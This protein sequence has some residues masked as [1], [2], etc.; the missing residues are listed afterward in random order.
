MNFLTQR[1]D[2]NRSG[3]YSKETILTVDTVKTKNFRK[4]SEFFVDGSVYA[5]PLVASKINIGSK[6]VDLLIVA[7]MHN[8][9]YAF[10]VTSA[11]EYKQLW[12]QRLI[13]NRPEHKDPKLWGYSIQ[14]PHPDIGTV[15]RHTTDGQPWY[16]DISWEV[17]I[18]ST[19]VIDLDDQLIYVV[20]T[21]QS[22]TA[23]PSDPSGTITHT[24]WKLDLTTGAD[25][26]HTQIAATVSEDNTSNNVKKFKS[27]QHIQRA[28]LAINKNGTAKEVY[29]AFAGY[30]DQCDWQG[31]I[32]GYE[33][34]SIRVGS[35]PTHTF[36]TEPSPAAHGSGIWQ[37]GTGPAVDSNGSLYVATGNGYDDKSLHTDELKSDPT[38]NPTNFAGRDKYGCMVLKLSSDLKKVQSSY[39]PDPD[40]KEKLS[41]KDLDLGSG[42]VLLIPGKEDNRALAVTGGKTN[43]IYVMRQD[44]LEVAEQQ[45]D[46]SPGDVHTQHHLHG[47]PTYYQDSNKKE[48]RYV[49]PEM[50]NMMKYSLT[51]PAKP[52]RANF[53]FKDRSAI[54]GPDKDQKGWVAGGNNGMPGGFMT[55]SCNITPPLTAPLTGSGIVWANHP[56]TGNA[57]QA[58]RP[59][60]LYA[61]DA[62]NINKPIW[63]SR[64][65]QDEDL[66]KPGEVLEK[67][68]A[69]DD[70]GNF[71]KF[72]CPTV[73][74]GRVY[75]ASMGGLQRLDSQKINIKTKSSPH[76]ADLSTQKQLMM[77]AW[78]DASDSTVKT[79]TST[80]S[81]EW[82]STDAASVTGATSQLSPC[83]A[84]D[85]TGKNTYIAWVD[86]STKALKMKKLSDSSWRNA[87]DAKM[88]TSAWSSAVE[89]SNLPATEPKYGPAITFGSG[90][91][92]LAWVNNAG[93][94]SVN[95]TND[96]GTTWVPAPFN[97]AVAGQRPSS[98]GRPWLV[99]HPSNKDFVLAWTDQTSGA[100]NFLEFADVPTVDFKDTITLSKEPP[101]KDPRPRTTI[102]NS[103]QQQPDRVSPP[104]VGFA[105]DFILDMFETV[106]GTPESR[107]FVPVIAFVTQM[108]KQ[109]DNRKIQ[110]GKKEYENWW[111]LNS[112]VS[113]GTDLDDLRDLDFSTRYRLYNQFDIGQY[114][115]AEPS[116]CRFRNR[117]YIA[118]I[119]DQQTV[120]VGILN[121]GSVSMYG[122]RTK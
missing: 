121:R 14:L 38:K 49:W 29:I 94:I 112:A 78:T 19:P 97:T 53:V 13:T 63:S 22:E 102:H 67:N 45:L 76:L 95:S 4:L 71:A 86:N 12:R 47:T 92:V 105:I 77:L 54:S 36:C 68:I 117:M 35:G 66:I 87:P 2:N 41:E 65:K 21:N 61:F 16:K 118:W 20:S 113:D 25:K 33:V 27:S 103:P 90:K 93:L 34:N 23:L 79:L 109:D 3:L 55:V 57:N 30:N 32:L 110:T 80:D 106:S 120:N 40:H 88:P 70:V 7:T 44:N 84:Y 82:V 104:D 96:G 108:G 42:G 43:V 74:N 5:Q 18:L 83:V 91:L 50:M 9:V 60:V 116:L 101:V 114:T 26:G 62:D 46:I 75:Q 37:A 56:W 85:S 24:L 81:F 8:S 72:C 10:D 59:G 11:G 111:A 99:Y 122:L 28:A 100:L 98:R 51:N 6:P 52:D 107:R 15:P 48:Y 64:K 119:S 73:A 31:W 89:M 69:A 39:Q 115:L 1:E 17:G 58:V